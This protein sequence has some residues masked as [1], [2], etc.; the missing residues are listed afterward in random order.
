MIKL[1][2]FDLGVT[3]IDKYSL[4]PLVNLNKAFKYRR[5]SLSKS[6]LKKIW[7]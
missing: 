5:I 6:L 2:V 4:S 7:G 3:L 1:V